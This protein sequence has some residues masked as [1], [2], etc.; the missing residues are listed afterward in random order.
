MDKQLG[1]VNFSRIMK[2][3]MILLV[4]AVVVHLLMWLMFDSLQKYETK[5]DPKPSPLFQKNQRPP[6]PQLQVNP[7]RDYKQLRASEDQVLNSYGWVDSE[8]GIVR[9]PISE[10]MK[11]VVQKEKE[12]QQ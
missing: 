1:D 2:A 8:K 9:I 10:A 11:V 3:G 7:T 12:A 4:V 5:I 6:A